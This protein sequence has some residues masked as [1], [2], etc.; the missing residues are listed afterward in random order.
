ML[1]GTALPISMMTGVLLSGWLCTRLVKRDARWQLGIPLIG[2]GMT[3]P[4]SLAYYL[5]PAETRMQFMGLEM[6][7]VMLFFI[8]M[9]FFS[10][11]IYAASTAALNN[12]IPAHQR[13]VANALNLVFYTVLGFGLGPASVGMLSDALTQTAGQEGLRYA[14]AILTSA[15][16]VSTLFYA[17]ALKP[18]LEA[19]K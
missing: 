12:V 14:L 18:Y 11:W 10:S 5:W 9:C 4:A 7:Q 3:I 13:S 1:T 17:K 2:G 16:A 8:L 15:M 19:N 6:P